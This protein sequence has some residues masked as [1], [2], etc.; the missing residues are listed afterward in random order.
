MPKFQEKRD[1]PF[2]DKNTGPLNAVFRTTKDGPRPENLNSVRT[3]SLRDTRHRNVEA[4]T[5]AKI[6][7]T[8]R[9]PKKENTTL[10]CAGKVPDQKLKTQTTEQ[11]L[12]KKRTKHS[13]NKSRNSER[14]KQIT[15]NDMPQPEMLAQIL[16]HHSLKAQ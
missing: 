9:I 10:P 1:D 7:G 8:P 11:T 13:K 2:A 5:G 16:S 15:L 6:T 3:V 4:N 14:H 12:S